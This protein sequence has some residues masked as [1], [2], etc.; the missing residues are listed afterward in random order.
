MWNKL[1]QLL[2]DP[3]YKRLGLALL[4]SV[5]LHSMLFGSLSFALPSLKKEMHVIEARIQMPKAVPKPV[6][7]AVQEPEPVVVKAESAVEPKIEEVTEPESVAEPTP[8]PV[9]ETTPNL[10]VRAEP[11]ASVAELKAEP[12]AERNRFPIAID[13]QAQPADIGLVINENAYQY[14]ETDFEVRTEVDGSAQGTAKI[15]YNLGANQQYQLNWLTKPKGVAAI[16]IGELLQTSEGALT[17]TGLQPSA[18]LYQ[19]DN[20]VDKT[21]TAN[22]DWQTKKVILQTTR[23][24]KTADLPDGA[25]DLL[26]FM[27]QFMHV[28]P[29]QTMQIAITNGKKMDLYDYKFEGEEQVNSPLGELKTIHIVHNTNGEEDKTELWLATDYQYLPVKI[30]KTEADGKV[31]EL[32]ATHINTSRPAV[33]N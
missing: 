6:E 20:K 24:T 28:A 13:D 12:M 15:V 23:G 25:Q 17:K 8:E 14:V 22:F 31:Y 16:F 30:R 21:R 11:L 7:A 33:P 27:Y 19:F 32:V 3:S 5:I 2:Q 1:A 4:V 18:Y 26:S 10:E 29:L 9:A